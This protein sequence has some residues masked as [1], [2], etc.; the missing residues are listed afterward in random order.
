MSELEPKASVCGGHALFQKDPQL[1]KPV[2]KIKKN[3]SRKLFSR[4]RNS[5]TPTQAAQKK[6]QREKQTAREAHE[7]ALFVYKLPQPQFR[8]R[9]KYQKKNRAKKLKAWSVAFIVFFFFFSS[10]EFKFR[11]LRI[12][13]GEASGAHRCV[14]LADL[15]RSRIG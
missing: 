14:L 6:S 8:N 7:N 3:R 4:E 5:H 11:F 2:K 10:S 12:V 15:T 1:T 13:A 9:E